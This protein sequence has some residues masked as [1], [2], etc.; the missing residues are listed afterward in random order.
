[1]PVKEL[2]LAMS[3]AL[4]L[5]GCA[6]GIV[7]SS[8]TDASSTKPEPVPKLVAAEVRV[9]GCLRT[10][11]DL[12]IGWSMRR[13]WCGNDTRRSALSAH[14]VR[15]LSSSRILRNLKPA[16]STHTPASTAPIKQAPRFDSSRIRKMASAEIT[17][18]PPSGMVHIHA[19]PNTQDLVSPEPEVIRAE[20][21][22]ASKNVSVPSDT[23]VYYARN[24]EAL[25]PKGREKVI[26][27]LPAAKAA[28][29]ITLLG[30]YEAEEI[31]ALVPGPQLE[32]RFSV[33]RSLSVRELWRSK[34]VDVSKVTI[35]HHTKTRSGRFVEVNFL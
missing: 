14:N 6:G 10:Q 27:L 21:Q 5:G 11:R 26:S 19:M 15:M 16:I 17:P 33:G 13:Y 24:R 31:K 2:A 12:T 22:N 20:T 34:G 9:K 23:H 8:I 32:E 35:R 18:S 30:L 29:H 25:G 4:L 7:K 1:M 28:S 3:I